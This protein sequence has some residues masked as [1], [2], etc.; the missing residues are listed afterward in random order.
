MET[1]NLEHLLCN[2]QP[3]LMIG[4][5]KFKLI[6]SLAKKKY[7]LKEQSFLAE[8]DKIVQEVLES[9]IKV[10]ELFATADF[11]SENKK[12]LRNVTFV[13]ETT[14]AEIKKASLLQQ[15][16]NCLAICHLP[17]QPEIPSNPLG[18]FL[19][20]DGIQ[21]P[22]NLGTIIRTCDWF[23]MNYLFCSPDTADVFNPKVIQATMGSFTRVKTIYSSYNEL[24]GL[25][26]NSEF[27]IFGTFLEG[28]DIYTENLPGN[29]LVV[30]GNEGSGIRKEVADLI[31]NRIKIP[32]F[33]P[34][35]KKAESLNV[36]VSAAIICNEFARKKFAIQNEN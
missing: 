3:F 7:R 28:K 18:I 19:Y 25:F 4:K 26:Q 35:E 21:D 23:G 8:G 17:P 31:G 16:Q 33:N 29:A 30:L 36:A 15:P 12:N 1:V 5:N 9:E 6:K 24:S 22:G 2:I 14:P 10:R 34:S 13:T 20:L 11:I 32:S 27:K